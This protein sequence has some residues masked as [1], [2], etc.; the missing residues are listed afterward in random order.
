LTDKEQF[1]LFDDKLLVRAAAKINLSLLVG[2]NRP[3]GYHEVDTIMAKVNWYD[4][5]TFEQGKKEGIELLCTGDC[6][7]PAGAENLVFQACQSACETAAVRPR[8]KVTLRKN[9]PAG[10]GLGSASSDAAAAL[11]G[12]N[13]FTELGLSEGQ[14]FELGV[15]LGSDVGF[16]LS[17]PL[18]RCTGRGERIR[19]I[20]QN[21]DFLALLILPGINVSTKMVYDDY[22][23]DADVYKKLNGKINSYIT[24][25]RIDLIVQMCANMLEGTCFRLHSELGKLKSCV[26]SLGITPVCLSGSGGAMFYI[27]QGK[28]KEKAKQYQQMLQDRV[29]CKSVIV[30]NNRW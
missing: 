3:D 30:N 26:E 6:R 27:V 13:R 18:A 28:D 29:D 14:L 10:S 7:A 2:D 19:K 21:F 4:E 16:F 22:E 12:I 5:L 9:I 8:I 20:E 24:K 25:N 23:Y 15:E 1:A 17:G 11:L